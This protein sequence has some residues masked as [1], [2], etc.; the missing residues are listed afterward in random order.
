M[1]PTVAQI[2]SYRRDGFVVATRWNAD[3]AHP[4][5]SRSARG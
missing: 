3:H 1:Q 4:I 2:E 5:Y